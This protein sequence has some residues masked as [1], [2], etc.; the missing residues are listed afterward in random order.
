VSQVVAGVDLT[1]K[2]TI[3][4]IECHISYPIHNLEEDDMEKLELYPQEK[5]IVTV[6]VE[7]KLCIKKMLLRDVNMNNQSII[8]RVRLFPEEGRS[9]GTPIHGKM[10]AIQQG[11]SDIFNRM[12]N[13]ADIVML[14]WYFFQAGA[15]ISD[16]KQKI[17]P[18]EGVEVED[19]NKILFPKWNIDIARYIDLFNIF[20]S[21]WERLS[22][23]SEPR[24]GKTTEQKT[25]AT[26]VLAALEEG[27]VRFNYQSET[28]KEE[29]LDIIR[30]LYDLYYQWMPYTGKTILHQG[31]EMPF[32]RREMRRPFNFRLTG[33]TEK[34][35]RLIE[36]K[37][38]EDIF[39]LTNQDPII[40]QV[41]TRE[42]LLK[43][44]GKDNIDEYITPE[45]NQLI[46]VYMMAPEEVTQALQPVIEA[47]QAM[48]GG[49]AA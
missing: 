46:G 21:L 33:S 20:I 49:K 2:E 27:N 36:R 9:Y 14:P 45:I 28:F 1:G 15:G 37:E 38:S 34:A 39:Q 44:Y 32:P 29:F 31:R 11:A 6:A 10:K 23:M 26:E 7:S 48:E 3:K 16:D 25:T 17:M 22:A 43:S 12:I 35:N 40:N 5:C 47:I 30:T 13:V 8:K 42:D 19:I 24:I 4:C 41:K 18:G